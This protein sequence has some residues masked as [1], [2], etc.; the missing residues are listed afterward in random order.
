MAL[1]QTACGRT[2]HTT[3]VLKSGLSADMTTAD[4]YTKQLASDQR[5]KKAET[6][7]GKKPTYVSAE[8]EEVYARK[9][10]RKR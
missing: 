5:A 10:Q 3:V 9:N 6:S 4:I 1:D 7:L 2:L 8:G